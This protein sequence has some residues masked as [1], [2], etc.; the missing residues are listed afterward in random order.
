MEPQSSLPHSRVPATCLYLSQIDSV[1]AHISHLL[2]MHLNMIL[3][4][5]PGSSKWFLSL[6]FSHQNPVYTS[7]LPRRAT[8]PA[9]LIIFDLV[10]RTK[11]G[12]YRTLSS[13]LCSFLHFPVTPSLLGPNIL[14]SALF[15]NTLSLRS[16]PHPP[17]QCERLSFTPIQNN[18]QNYSSVYL[19][20]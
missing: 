19:N 10:N 14:V 16:L 3:P 4:S 15:S 5:T 18:R 17:S 13:S 6:R 8:C 2:K 1:H 20:L 9:H 12:E 7:L 11:L